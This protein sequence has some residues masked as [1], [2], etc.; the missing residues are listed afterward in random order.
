[1]PLIYLQDIRL[2]AVV[3]GPANA[4]P[5]LFC[6]ALGTDLTLWDAILPALSPRFRCIR[7]DARGHG[8]SDV[9][10]PPYTMGALIRDAERL[11][12]HFALKDAVVV[13]NGFDRAPGAGLISTE[14]AEHH[15]GDLVE[16]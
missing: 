7:Y 13:G 2:N 15:V 14:E 10:A 16:I 12:T 5:L 6:H 3:E 11:M 1:M 9:P 4:P 8:L